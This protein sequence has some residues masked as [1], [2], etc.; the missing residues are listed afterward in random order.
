MRNVTKKF[1]SFY[2][3]HTFFE[4]ED[5][6]M[7]VE[8]TPVSDSRYEASI[9]EIYLVLRSLEQVRKSTEKSWSSLECPN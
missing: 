9:Q 3:L 1:P 8:A 5:Q 4:Q 2:I 7:K 6:I